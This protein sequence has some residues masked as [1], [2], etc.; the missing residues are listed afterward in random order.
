MPELFP[1]SPELF[2]IVGVVLPPPDDSFSAEVEPLFP[3]PPFVVV[4]VSLL[5]FSR[6]V[7][8]DSM[9]KTSTGDNKQNVLKVKN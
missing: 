9:L 4:L 7:F 6:K 8:N 2:D 3:P 1:P 5:R